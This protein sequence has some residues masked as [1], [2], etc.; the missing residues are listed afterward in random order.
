[1]KTTH[2]DS[3]KKWKRGNRDKR[4]AKHYKETQ[5]PCDNNA[6]GCPSSLQLLIPETKDNEIVEMPGMISE[7]HF[8][9]LKDPVS[10]EGIQIYPK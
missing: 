8:S 10:T 5:K 1:M 9:F 2:V 7:P 6:L 4:C 3:C